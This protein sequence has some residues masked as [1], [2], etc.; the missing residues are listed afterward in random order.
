VLTIGNSFA[1]SVFVFLPDVVKSVPD[2]SLVIDRGNHGGCE[3][4]RH[5]GYIEKEEADPSV[6]IYK[7]GTV[8]LSDI[9][10]SEKWDIVTI[11]QASHKSWDSSSYFPFAQNIYDFVKKYAPQ[12]E[13]V[14]QQTWAYRPDDPRIM[15][16]GAWGFDQKG[17]Y[18]R[19]AAAY[20][21]A[22][23]KLNA[24]LIPTGFAVQLARDK[25][26]VKYQNYD[27]KILNTLSW[28]DLP[29]QAG[30]PAGECSWKKSKNG[31]LSINRDSIHLNDRGRYLQACVW[32]AFLFDRPASDIKFVPDDI[33]AKDAEFLRQIAQEA[34][35]AY[36]PFNAKK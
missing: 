12:A 25:G 23:K 4:E 14:I 15:Q 26:S 11:Q 6:K 24:R 18:A 1:D 13:I 5:W 36:K 21:E 10:K 9:L 8:K 31:E 35:D 17:M 33:G 22:A 27:P 29:P 19:L 30:D 7:K 20:E 16:G 2:C 34:V 28:P 3:L 32:F